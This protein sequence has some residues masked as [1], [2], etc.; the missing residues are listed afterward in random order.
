MPINYM[1]DI[2]Y[3]YIRYLSLLSKIYF[4]HIFQLSDHVVNN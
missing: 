4:L 1:L 2:R 3:L